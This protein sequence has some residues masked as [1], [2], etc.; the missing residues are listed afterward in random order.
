MTSPFYGASFVLFKSPETE[1]LGD[2]LSWPLFAW[3]T[4]AWLIIK[5]CFLSDK[6]PLPVGYKWMGW[7]GPLNAPLL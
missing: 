2:I 6:S 4:F 3:F 5:Q 7:V 1:G